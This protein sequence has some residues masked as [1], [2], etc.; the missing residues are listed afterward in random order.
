[1]FLAGW[2][3]TFGF[4]PWNKG[5]RFIFYIPKQRDLASRF[6]QHPSVCTWHI[7]PTTLNY[8]AQGLG[9]P[10][11]RGSSLYNPEP[12]TLHIA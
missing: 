3:L 6:S 9:C 10:S 2:N 8:L 11:P 7:L 5:Q 1:M 12:N 4:G